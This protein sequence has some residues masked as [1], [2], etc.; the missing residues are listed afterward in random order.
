MRKRFA[1]GMPMRKTVRNGE[2]NKSE[3]EDMLGALHAIG[4]HIDD[5]ATGCHRL[6]DID[7]AMR[8]AFQ[9]LAEQLDS[10]NDILSRINEKIDE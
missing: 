9:R 3:F 7:E 6:R 4:D 1:M 2:M 5:V 8:V 10:I